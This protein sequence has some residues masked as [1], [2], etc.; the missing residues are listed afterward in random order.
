MFNLVAL[1]RIPPSH[2]LTFSITFFVHGAMLDWS[3]H[4]RQRFRARGRGRRRV[5]VLAVGG[6]R[7][8]PVLYQGRKKG[9]GTRTVVLGCPSGQQTYMS[10]VLLHTTPV[11]GQ[12][13]R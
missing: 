5:P 4:K 1:A 13:I 9:Q 2:P 6:R 10:K 12:P 11:G 8:L 7:Y 3:T